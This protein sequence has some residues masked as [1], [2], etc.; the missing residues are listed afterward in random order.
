MTCEFIKGIVEKE[1]KIDLT[2]ES[3][4]RDIVDTRDCY[5]F[6]CRKY[7]PKATLKEIATTLNLKSHSTVMKGLERFNLFYGTN[8]YKA[9]EVY[10]K[11]NEKLLYLQKNSVDL[12]DFSTIKE[13][14]QFY[15]L[16]LLNIIEQ[17]HRVINILQSRISELSK[18]RKIEVIY[19]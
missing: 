11:C 10:V 16:R 9:N 15:K 5:Y 17:N 8:V 1:S 6:L 13:V 14:E 12:K 3:R 19:Q 7:A 2:T 18:I 4:V